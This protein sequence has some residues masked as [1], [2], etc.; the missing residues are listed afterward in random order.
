MLLATE[1]IYF[2]ESAIIVHTAI[3]M[4]PQR[5]KRQATRNKTEEK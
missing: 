2:S 3:K 1:P 5:K 4:E